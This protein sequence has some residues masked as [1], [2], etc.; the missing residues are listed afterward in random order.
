MMIGADWISIVL[1][2]K[3]FDLL[4]LDIEVSQRAGGGG[5]RLEIKN[6]YAAVPSIS[7]VMH[8]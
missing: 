2:E 5:G 4:G 7:L 1:P 6:V 8:Y 3:L